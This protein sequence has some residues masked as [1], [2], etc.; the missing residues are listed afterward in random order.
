MDRILV[1][2]YWRGKLNG[3]A[4]VLEIQCQVVDKL[5]AQGKEPATSKTLSEDE[6]PTS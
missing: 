4:Q 6:R 2:E 3:S 1:K 5:P